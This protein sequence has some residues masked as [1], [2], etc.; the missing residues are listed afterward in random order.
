MCLN[1]QR[2]TCLRWLPAI[3]LVCNLATAL[4]P[5]TAFGADEIEGLEGGNT[6]LGVSVDFSVEVVSRA[7]LTDTDT[8]LA[9][10][11]Y[12]AGL[13]WQFLLLDFDHR[14]SHWRPGTDLGAAPGREAWDSLTRISPGVQYYGEFG[15]YWG[16]WVKGVAITGFERNISSQSWTYNPQVIGLYMPR[17]G[18]TF[19]AGVGSLYHPVDTTLYPALGVAWNMNTGK[20][21][22]GALGFPETML[23]YHFS[24]RL[25]VKADFQ[26]DIRIYRLSAENPTAPSGYIRAEDLKPGI[27]LEY[28]PTASLQVIAGVRRFFGRNMTVFSREELELANYKIDDAQSFRFEMK[29][30]F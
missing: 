17:E 1:S 7:A 25:A 23:R 19:Y 6:N 2:I 4:W 10:T 28:L 15:E 16:L 13:S 22:S 14:R 30:K 5:T 24:E 8:S 20:G 9:F 12:S 11:E 3:L 29:Y 21:L 26:W 27:H 18:L